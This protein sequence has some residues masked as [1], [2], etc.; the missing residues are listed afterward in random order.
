MLTNCLL[1]QGNGVKI[2]KDVLDEGKATFMSCTCENYRHYLWCVHVC[3]YA[4]H[5][6]IITCYPPNLVPT[7][8]RSVKSKAPV[9]L[10]HRPAKAQR[11]G[12]LSKK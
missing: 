8:I 3:C 7:T 12:A 4:M 10:N 6:K 2:A 5:K 1:A 11:G 9:A